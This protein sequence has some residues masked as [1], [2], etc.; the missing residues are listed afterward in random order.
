MG[1][2]DVHRLFGISTESKPMWK[3]CDVNLSVNLVWAEI[4]V[5]FWPYKKLMAEATLTPTELAFNSLHG[6]ALLETSVKDTSCWQGDERIFLV[7]LH[8]EVFWNVYIYV[9][10]HMQ[11]FGIGVYVHIHIYVKIRCFEMLFSMSQN[12]YI[13]K[14]SK[15]FSKRKEVP[16]N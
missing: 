6:S 16:L 11:L 12:E 2:G 10:K 3:A 8:L 15:I 4:G 9:L 5:W 13:L 7:V 14:L 1:G